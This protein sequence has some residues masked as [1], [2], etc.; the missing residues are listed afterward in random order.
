MKYTAVTKV[1]VLKT[2]KNT[3]GYEYQ[4]LDTSKVLGYLN[5]RLWTDVN[6]YAIIDL[7]PDGKHATAVEV[8]IPTA[9]CYD[10]GAARADGIPDQI[11]VHGKP[12]KVRY[13]YKKW[14]EDGEGKWDGHRVLAWQIS[15]H[16]GYHYDLSF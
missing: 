10:P 6:S 11:C 4:I 16:C 3:H 13:A 14:R 12:F 5:D 2:V 7:S 15:Q 1:P 8:Y 9:Q